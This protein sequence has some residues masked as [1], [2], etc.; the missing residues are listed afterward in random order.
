MSDSASEYYRRERN[1]KWIPCTGVRVV[2][3]NENN[4]PDGYST[5]DSISCSGG[6]VE[7]RRGIE[8]CG[9]DTRP[10]EYECKQG[11]ASHYVWVQENIP[12][13]FPELKQALDV[14]PLGF[15]VMNRNGLSWRRVSQKDL[16]REG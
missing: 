3:L 7:F 9:E 16:R 5:E 6:L 12:L 8:R 2:F 11:A 14:L 10:R 13:A 15:S 4:A 1:G